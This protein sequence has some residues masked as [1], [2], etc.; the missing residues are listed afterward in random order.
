MGSTVSSVCLC[1]L[2]NQSMGEWKYGLFDCINPLNLKCL[3]S[4]YCHPCAIHDMAE[5]YEPGTGMFNL[6]LG[7]LLP[8]YPLVTLRGKAREK[9]QI[10][11]SLPG[12]CCTMCC[13]ASC[14]II[15]LHKQVDPKSNILGLDQLN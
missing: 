1:L 11:G 3:Y 13:C 4:V 6:V 10:E 9:N 15:Q 2:S 8:I 7:L 12:D 14:A 5:E